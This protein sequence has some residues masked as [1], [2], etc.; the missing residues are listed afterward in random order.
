MLNTL[1]EYQQIVIDVIYLHKYVLLTSEQFDRKI[2]EIY[3]KLKIL[4]FVIVLSY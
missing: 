4:K 3:T 2:H 1:Q